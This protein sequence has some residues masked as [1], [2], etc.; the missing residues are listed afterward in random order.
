MN[1]ENGLAAALIVQ[2]RQDLVTH[3]TL[4]VWRYLGSDDVA[5][6][7]QAI[8]GYGTSMNVGHS[9]KDVIDI[10]P[11]LLK[12]GVVHKALSVGQ[13]PKS[14]PGFGYHKWVN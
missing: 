4:P 10:Y 11:S 1:L 6:H 9:E 14:F 3:L 8:V 5:V 12:I 13:V 7:S 2:H